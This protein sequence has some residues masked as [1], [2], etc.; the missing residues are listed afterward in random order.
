MTIKYSSYIS[1]DYKGKKYYIR[2][3]L[4]YSISET[5]T[6]KKITFTAGFQTK[7]RDCTLNP[8]TMTVS[9][10]KGNKKSVRKAWAGG[11][12][13]KSITY[14]PSTTFTY[15]KTSADQ[16]IVLTY[17]G[18]MTGTR[19]G[20]KV[21]KGTITIEVSALGKSSVVFT[22]DRKNETTASLTLNIT[23]PTGLSVA[24][25]SPTVKKDGT[26]ISTTWYRD[27]SAVTF[28]LT[29]SANT[30]LTAE[31]TVDEMH[32]CTYEYTGNIG[33]Y[34]FS[35]TSS[36]NY[37]YFPEWKYTVTFEGTVPRLNYYGNAIMDV[38]AWDYTKEGYTLL[39]NDNGWEITVIDT[40]H[41]SLDVALTEQ[42]VATPTSHT[43]EAKIELQYSTYTSNAVADRMAIFNT[44]R[45]ATFSTGLAN[46]V[47]IGGCQTTKYNSRVWYSYVNNPLYMPDTY[48]IEVGSN[49]TDVMGLVKIGD[50][51]G[52]IKQSKTVD[53]SIFLVY[54]TSFENETTFATKPCVSGVGALG[55]YCFNVLGDETLFLSPDGVMAIEPYEDE[56]QRV[57]DRSYYINKQLLSE[58]D[59]ENAYS[60]V[61]R[62]FYLLAVNNHVYILDGNQRNSWGN[63][64]TNLVY[65]CYYFDNV[66]AKCFFTYGGQ[67]WFSDFNGNL[68]RFKEKN[69]YNAY[70]DEDEPV[71][72]EWATIADDDG[73]LQYFKNL[74][75]KGTLVSLLPEEGTT[76]RVYLKKDEGDPM[77][78]TETPPLDDDLTLPSS[79]YVRKKVK[80]YKRLQFIVE[81]DTGNPFGIDRIVKSYT[82]GSYAKK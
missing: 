43:S 17:A 13:T 36:I 30:V 9:D 34:S 41:F 50:N 37:Y 70:Y 54:P 40:T 56:Q 75:K 76:A 49:D 67:L 44:N 62:G 66:P 7:T 19:F 39:P 69:E 6:Q 10:T 12:A 77:L 72:A 8:I 3:W 32:G 60:F 68:C 48:F 61:W 52:V 64:K 26:A 45:S 21:P 11:S 5:A 78:I 18:T 53:T 65:E 63:T 59:L 42:Y 33:A 24:I 29:V 46:N 81:D 55:K 73:A 15:N 28:P 38:Y 80:K 27:G 1:A 57:K 2:S 25:T 16:K 47:F 14:V 82:V 20:G 71:R 58:H 31:N 4:N 35:R 74:G 79:V 51:L 23:P 22:A